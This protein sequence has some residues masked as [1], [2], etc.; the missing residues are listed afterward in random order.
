MKALQK[1]IRELAA[2]VWDETA[3]SLKLLCGRPSPM[4]RMCA[5]L[6][7]CGILAAVNLWYV[8]SSIYNMGKRDTERNF[9][10]IEHIQPFELLQSK[11]SI[12]SI[13][14]VLK[15]EKVKQ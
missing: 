6:L 8:A 1:K 9:V 2:D 5:M 3:Y 13:H 15:Q 12:D 7:V 14:S 11:E 4:K 10:E